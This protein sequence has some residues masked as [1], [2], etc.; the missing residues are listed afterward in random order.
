[1]GRGTSIYMSIAE[2]VAEHA[3]T[4][5]PEILKWVTEVAEQTEPARIEWCDGSQTEWDRIAQEM[6]DA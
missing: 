3:T 6:V 1:M 4:T 2:L 5:N